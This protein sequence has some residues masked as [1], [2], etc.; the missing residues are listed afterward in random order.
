MFRVIRPTF[1]VVK[2]GPD[3]L[4]RKNESGIFLLLIEHHEKLK[5]AE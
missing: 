3:F 5:S 2:E 4:D 1:E